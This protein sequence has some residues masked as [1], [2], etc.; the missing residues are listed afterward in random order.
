PKA[1]V[2]PDPVGALASTSRPAIASGRTMA[3]TGVGVTMFRRSKTP[4]TDV[5]TPSSGK[6]CCCIRFI[7]LAAVVG[8]GLSGRD[9]HPRPPSQGGTGGTNPHG[10]ATIAVRAQEDTRWEP[11]SG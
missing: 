6:V 4:V 9:Q 10:T 5:A 2:L 8:R 7:L 11:Q 3:W 1:S